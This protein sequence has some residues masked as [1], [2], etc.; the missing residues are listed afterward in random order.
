MKESSW[1]DCVE[2]GSAVKI[3]PD[4]DDAEFFALCLKFSCFLWS[5][6]SMLKN[7][8]INIGI[9]QIE[10]TKKE[11]AEAR[12]EIKHGK[13]HTLEQIKKELKI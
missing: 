12:E 13:F 6:D 8:G 7:Q 1:T 2:E 3:S 4:K 10:E 5:N 11:L 9:D